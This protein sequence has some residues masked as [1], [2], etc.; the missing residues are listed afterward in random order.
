ME[1]VSGQIQL[2]VQEIG[3]VIKHELKKNMAK[4]IQS[5]LS[6]DKK[7]IGQGNAT[8]YSQVGSKSARMR[9]T[10]SKSEIQQAPEATIN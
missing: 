9:S 7:A 4:E 8:A 2:T 5:Y 6:P 1:N 3:L 10:E